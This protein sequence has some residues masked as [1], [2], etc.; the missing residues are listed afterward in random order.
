MPRARFTLR[1]LVGMNSKRRVMKNYAYKLY[2]RN[3]VNVIQTLAGEKQQCATEKCRDLIIATNFGKMTCVAETK[4]PHQAPRG[5][6][7]Y[8]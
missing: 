8:T 6:A 5:A 7:L 3:L 4:K 1:F 2:P